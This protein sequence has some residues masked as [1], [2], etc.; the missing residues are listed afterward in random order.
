MSYAENQLLLAIARKQGE[1]GS[2]PAAQDYSACG[3]PHWDRSAWD[4]FRAQYG[5]D[6]F[7]HD[8]KGGWITPPNYD[9]AP[10]WV[11]E[12]MGQRVPPIRMRQG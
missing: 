4:A 11:F 10:D 6:P 2:A 12:K 9:G 8:G 5:H 1:K 7:G 3:P